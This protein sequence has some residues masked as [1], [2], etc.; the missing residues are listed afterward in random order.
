M[1]LY[2]KQYRIGKSL[3]HAIDC[4][5]RWK[6]EGKVLRMNPTH[7]EIDAMFKAFRKSFGKM[8]REKL[9]AKV[10][11]TYIPN[12]DRSHD[13]WIVIPLKGDKG[14]G[15]KLSDVTYAKWVMK[16]CKAMFEA[17]LDWNDLSQLVKMLKR[18]KIL[19]PKL[20]AQLIF[21]VWTFHNDW[22]PK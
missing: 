17:L 11:S 8:Q 12:P 19:K 1:A 13:S 6:P 5:R 7:T 9:I 15:F 3:Y 2:K 4:D 16:N 14:Y 10:G 18:K 20:T 22:I 21:A